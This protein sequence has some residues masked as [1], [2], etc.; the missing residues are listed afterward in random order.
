MNAKKHRGSEPICSPVPPPP[1]PELP[2]G[3]FAALIGLD[4]GDRKHAIALSPRET[5]KIEQLEIEHSAENLHRWIQGL[6]ER[7]GGRPVAFA[8]E[9]TKGAVV[10]ALLEYPWVIIYPIHPATSHRFSTAFSPSGAKG[11]GPDARVLLDILR[12]HRDRLRALLPHDAETR[13]LSQLVETRRSRVNL[14]T[15][16]TN[17]VVSLL[18]GY[19]PQAPKF[20]GANR[21]APMALD[22]LDRYPDLQSLQAARPQTLRSFYYSHHVRSKQRV[23]ERIQFAREAQPLTTD[24]AIIEVSVSQLKF[25]VTHIRLLNKEIASIEKTIESAFANHPEAAF[26]NGLPGAG[27]V[28]APRLTILFGVDR[29]R[30][31]NAAEMQKYFGVAPVI[32]ASG[33]MKWTHWRWNAPLFSRQ[34]LVEWSGISVQHSRWAAAYYQ[35]QDKRGKAHSTIIRSLAFKWLRILWRCWKDHT[36]YNEDLYLSRLEKRNPCFFALIKEL[37]K[38]FTKKTCPA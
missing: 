13:R 14:R 15:M 31:A 7:F 16:F 28:M 34:T 19:Y 36:P 30:W 20:F 27:E 8:I 4:F 3:E 23:E 5:N 6:A 33:K 10:S 11:D 26:F 12:C 32:E 9:S 35:Q 1:T 17:K 22:F 2:I 29:D 24:P 37:P 21:F 18:K 25:L 38:N